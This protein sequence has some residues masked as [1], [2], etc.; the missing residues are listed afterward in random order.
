MKAHYSKVIKNQNSEYINI[1][2]NLQ[3]KGRPIAAGP[4]FPNATYNS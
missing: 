1:T 2:E 3:V 4:A